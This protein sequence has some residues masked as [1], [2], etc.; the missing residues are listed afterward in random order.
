MVKQFQYDSKTMKMASAYALG[1]L[2]GLNFL[3]EKNLRELVA[4]VDAVRDDSKALKYLMDNKYY[5]HAAFVNAI[6]EDDKAFQLLLKHAPYLA[7]AARV[8]DG[9]LKA[10]EMLEK[11]GQSDILEF[12]YAIQKRIREDGDKAVNPLNAFTSIFKKKK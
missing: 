1:H 12:A 5:F 8:I 2:E 10:H 4:V 3:L 6:W 7:A 11:R 9:D